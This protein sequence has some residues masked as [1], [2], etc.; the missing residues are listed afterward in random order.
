MDK[1]SSVATIWQQ[2]FRLPLEAAPPEA[3]ENAR[4]PSLS[5]AV[6]LGNQAGQA[7]V[8][9]QLAM[10]DDDDLQRP[11]LALSFSPLTLEIDRTLQVLRTSKQHWP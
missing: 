5:I 4:H 6:R 7:R 9:G 3:A 10:L 8:L 1:L 11:E 2:I